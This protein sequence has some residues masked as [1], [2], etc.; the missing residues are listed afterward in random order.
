MQDNDESKPKEQE[1]PTV[2]PPANP[3]AALLGMTKEEEK[4][5][6]EPPVNPLAALLGMS[7][8]E[9]EPEDK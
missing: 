2:I 8:K 3:L 1:K 7:K 5:E 4:P 9:S 6:L